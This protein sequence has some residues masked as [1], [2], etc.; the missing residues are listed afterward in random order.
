MSMAVRSDHDGQEWVVEL[1]L[2]ALRADVNARQ[3][4]A[5]AG[6][7]AGRQPT[8]YWAWAG[9]WGGWNLGGR[10]DHRHQFVCTQL[11]DNGHKDNNRKALA[12][13]LPLQHILTVE[14][15]YCSH[16]APCLVGK[17]VEAVHISRKISMI[18]LFS[19]AGNH[20]LIVL[21]FVQEIETGGGMSGATASSAVSAT[22]RWWR[23]VQEV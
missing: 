23:A 7:V 11:C 20:E 8:D 3:P 6:V 14:R 19:H 2:R 9:L 22:F 5:I 10:L 13:C 1:L 21:V 18:E 16:V 17:R 15:S 12:T 4:A